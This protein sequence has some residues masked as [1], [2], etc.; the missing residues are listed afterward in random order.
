MAGNVFVTAYD[1][2][3]FLPNQYAHIGAG[4]GHVKTESSENIDAL[5]HNTNATASRN[6]GLAESAM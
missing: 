4:C 6:S 2:H 1:W 5:S 3:A